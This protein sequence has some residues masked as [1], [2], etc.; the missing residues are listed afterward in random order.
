MKS[1]LSLSLLLTRR[2]SAV[3]SSEKSSSEKEKNVDVEN[4]EKNEKK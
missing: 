1:E 2:T 4:E 3:V